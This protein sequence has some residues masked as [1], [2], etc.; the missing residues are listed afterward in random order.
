[1]S[2]H[3][4]YV[5]GTGDAEIA[6]LDGQAGSIAGATDA[7]LRAA[8]IGSDMRGLDLGTG[9]GH[10]AFMIAV[11]LDPRGSVLGVDQAERLLAVAEQRRVAAGLDNVG[12][13]R[14]GPGDV[15]RR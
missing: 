9:L 1:M 8:G 11:L 12:F 13:P 5:L 7:L 15:E 2:E 6:R 3:T 10:V 14:G 4:A